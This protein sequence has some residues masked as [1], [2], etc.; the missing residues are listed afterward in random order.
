MEDLKEIKDWIEL[1][2]VNTKRGCLPS[3]I[4]ENK[5]TNREGLTVDALCDLA[6]KGL[7]TR[8]DSDLVKSLEKKL[9]VDKKDADD[10]AAGVVVLTAKL[11]TARE[12]LKGYMYMGANGEFPVCIEC[13]AEE[14][15]ESGFD[16]EP[17]IKHQTDCKLKAFLG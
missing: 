14:E 3:N 5:K 17:N 4:F 1:Y 15:K 8:A 10:F 6:L 7:N 12:L 9:A 11:D 13:G 2:R 16:E